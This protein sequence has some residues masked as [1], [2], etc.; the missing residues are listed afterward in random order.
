M[1]MKEFIVCNHVGKLA[2]VPCIITPA[3]YAMLEFFKVSGEVQ[4]DL[5][6]VDK[7]KP[8]RIEN[9]EWYATIEDALVA[10]GKRLNAT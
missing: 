5:C 10:A 9:L 4:A 1:A 6:L 8:L 3:E 7:E 2:N